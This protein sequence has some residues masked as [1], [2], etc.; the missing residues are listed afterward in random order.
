MSS[1]YDAAYAR[2]LADPEGF[3]GEAAADVHWYRKWDRVL[4][5]SEAPFYRWFSGGMVNSCYSALD[6]HVEGGRGDQPALAREIAAYLDAPDA[7]ARAG[8]AGRERVL[9]HFTW[10]NAARETAALYEEVRDANSDRANGPTA[11]GRFPN[12]RRNEERSGASR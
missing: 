5:D 1:R 4:D 6:V 8:R 12:G 9:E 11:N 3:W 2:S 7:A 10:R